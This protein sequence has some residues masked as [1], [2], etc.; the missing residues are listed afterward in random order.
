MIGGGKKMTADIYSVA[1]SAVLG[2]F[3]GND[4]SS[5]MGNDGTDKNGRTL[6]AGA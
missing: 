4:D 3:T 2:T 6:S 1:F 5:T